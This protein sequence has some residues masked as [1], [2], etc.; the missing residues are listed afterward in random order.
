MLP[1]G[2]AEVP[3]YEASC[4]I[5]RLHRYGRGLLIYHRSPPVPRST[6]CRRRPLLRG[7]EIDAQKIT[8]LADLAQFDGTRF[9]W[10]FT[11]HL[12]TVLADL[13]DRPENL[14]PCPPRSDRHLLTDLVERRQSPRI[15]QID[16]A[17]RCV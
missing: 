16:A 9:D 8:G 6:P 5:Q 15:R 10:L 7:Q 12:R 14:A 2:R 4:R 3:G 1:R 17:R 13:K 11:L